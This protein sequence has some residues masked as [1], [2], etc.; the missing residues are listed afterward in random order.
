MRALVTAHVD[1]LGS[2]PDPCESG[3]DDRFGF[4]DEGDDRAVGRLAGVHIEQFHAAGRL[5]GR[6]NLS[7]HVFIASLAE[8]G[9]AFDDSVC[10]RIVALEFLYFKGNKHSEIFRKNCNKNDPLL[11]KTERSGAR[12]T[13]PR[14]QP[15][16]LCPGRNYLPM[17]STTPPVHQNPGRRRPPMS[18]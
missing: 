17:V 10:H 9:D 5:D 18:Q 12:C 3:L 15:E 8:I 16:G 4:A 11:Q 13:G 2:P 14:L 7:D 6:G 1:Q